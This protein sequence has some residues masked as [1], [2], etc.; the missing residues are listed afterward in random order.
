VKV[1][2]LDSTADATGKFVNLV[3]AVLKKKYPNGEISKLIV[4]VLKRRQDERLQID[5][6]LEC[7][8]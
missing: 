3:K 6:V 2:E 4:S 5:T 7:D 1:Q 8:F